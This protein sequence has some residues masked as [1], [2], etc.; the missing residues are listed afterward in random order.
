MNL[1][2]GS[3][4]RIYD[5]FEGVRL[6]GPNDLVFDEQGAMW[7][8]DLGKRFTHQRDHS[9]LYYARTDGSLLHRAV[10]PAVGLNGV[11]LSPDGRTVYCNETDT[12]RLW[13]Y[14]IEGPGRVSLSSGRGRLICTLPGFQMLDSLA[15][16]ASGRICSATLTNGG[17]TVFSPDGSFEHL[18]L[19]DPM[20]TNI[21]FGGAD[22]Q[23]AYITLSGSGRL[24]RTRWPRPGLRLN[25]NA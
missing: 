4:E 2:T 19:P 25:F 10:Y 14:D 21:C 5:S 1:A 15:V 8:T 23:D 3:F 22:M 18:P 9:G 16:E 6:G 11:G 7:F 13:A 17:I 24:V 12:A 20:T